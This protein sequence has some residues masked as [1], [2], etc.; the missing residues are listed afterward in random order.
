[1]SLG[2]L[3]W[4][5]SRSVGSGLCC[6]ENSDA[7]DRLTSQ[8]KCLNDIRKP[9]NQIPRRYDTKM[10]DVRLLSNAPQEREN[11]DSELTKQFYSSSDRPSQEG[12][13]TNQPT[14]AN[15]MNDVHQL[16]KQF[17]SSSDYPSQE[18]MDQGCTNG[19]S[20]MGNRMN[21]RRD[22]H[23]SYTSMEMTNL[24][25]D[26]TNS[27]SEANSDASF[28]PRLWIHPRINYLQMIET[29][30]T[31]SQLESLAICKQEVWISNITVQRIILH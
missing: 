22:D 9:P 4:K 19:W 23:L 12:N 27:S 8:N 16:E 29:H 20:W 26:P 18:C 5:M 3:S 25:V 17:K 6:G 21:S 14:E 15:S 2:H 10:L 30:E 28:N 31:N 13:K 24:L 1:M 7:S 11:K